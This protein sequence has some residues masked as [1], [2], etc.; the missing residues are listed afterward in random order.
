MRTIIKLTRV[1]WLGL[2]LIGA[3]AVLTFSPALAQGG[4]AAY[5]GITRAARTGLTVTLFLIGA[6]LSRDTLKT[7]G[8]KPVAHGVALW[9]LIS[10]ASLWAVTR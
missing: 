7:V 5:A 4:S 8:F 1:A 6:G 2:A 3:S 9:A 10:T